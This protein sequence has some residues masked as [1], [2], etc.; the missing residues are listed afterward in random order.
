[1]FWERS[2]TG[3]TGKTKRK[4]RKGLENLN[5]VGLSL[6]TSAKHR[7]SSESFSRWFSSRG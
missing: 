4:T 2:Q 5:D 3:G 7:L 1:M 6:P